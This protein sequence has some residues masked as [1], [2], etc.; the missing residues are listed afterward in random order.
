MRELT[1]AKTLNETLKQILTRN[2]DVILIGQG[3][4]SPWYV[5][6][7]TEGIV[8]EFGSDRVIDTPISES[9]VTGAAIGASFNGLH[10]ILMHPRMDFM[11]YAMDQI[12]NHAANWHYMFGGNVNVPLTV[13]A[14]IN[15]GGEQAAQHS[16]AT[17]TMY[18]H[19]PGLKIITPSSPYDLKGLLNSCIKEPN[20]V[21]FVDDR[22]LYE[23]KGDV[24]QD[25]YEIPFGKGVI[26]EKGDD[27]TIISSSY[28]IHE[29][30]KAVE[31]L[32]KHDIYPELIDLRTIKP[33]DEELIY[34]SVNRTGKAIIV[35][36]T[37]TSFG[38]SAE[39]SSLIHEN[40]FEHLKKSVKRIGLPDSPAPAS[41]ILENNY[42]IKSDLIVNEILNWVN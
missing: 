13:W 10:P 37:W 17:H 2:N 21:L 27:L 35:D 9:C 25:Y 19:V 28:L 32:H 15:R 4:T 12:I 30:K 36:G 38:I 14:I 40:C 3:V 16:Q 23:V 5:G 26:L 29:C 41:K 22:W 7:T 6:S 8:D 18:A 20:P 31:Q 1:Y 24:P 11:Y 39:I 42:Y 33:L 34:N